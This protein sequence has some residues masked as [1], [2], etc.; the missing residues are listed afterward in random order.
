MATLRMVPA[1]ND[2]ELETALA[3]AIAAG[4]TDLAASLVAL[5]EGRV[6]M[7]RQARRLA[8]RDDDIM[9]AVIL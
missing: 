5:R 1:Y 2:Q 3:A 6:R 7:R 9:A 4:D 8:G